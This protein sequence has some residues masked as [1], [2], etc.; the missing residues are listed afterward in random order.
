MTLTCSNIQ[1]KIRALGLIPSNIDA[2][3]QQAKSSWKGGLSPFA[4]AAHTLLLVE[5]KKRLWG[6]LP[7]GRG[8]HWFPTE[9]TRRLRVG[10]AHGGREEVGRQGASGRIIQLGSE[11]GIGR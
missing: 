8:N 5:H 9:R 6:A 11:K 10:D 1:R 7:I 4:R 2:I 3:Y